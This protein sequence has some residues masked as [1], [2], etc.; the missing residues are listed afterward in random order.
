VERS[1]IEG[2]SWLLEDHIHEAFVLAAEVMALANGD[3]TH[4][5]VP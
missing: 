5:R 2:C 3:D 4:S 1:R